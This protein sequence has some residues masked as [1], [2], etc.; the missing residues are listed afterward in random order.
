MRLIVSG[1]RVASLVA[2]MAEVARMTDTCR[3]RTGD[4]GGVSSH[5]S[6]KTEARIDDALTHALTPTAPARVRACYPGFY[7]RLLTSSPTI[8]Q[9]TDTF[10]LKRAH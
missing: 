10:F 5:Y 8:F 2:R 9:S 7:N 6:R 4:S 1:L 3:T